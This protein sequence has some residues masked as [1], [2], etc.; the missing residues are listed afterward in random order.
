MKVLITGGLGFVGRNFLKRCLSA[1]DEVTVVD[2]FSE[3]G[4]GLRPETTW[5]QIEKISSHDFE[6][7]EQDCRQFFESNTTKFDMAIHLASIVGGRLTIE[8]DPFEIA[9][10]LEIDLRFFR[11]ALKNPVA[12]VMLFSSS[13]VYPTHLQEFSSKRSLAESDLNPKN[14]SGFP[15]M[16]YG[17]GKLNLEVLT[18][19]FIGRTQTQTRI[20]RPFSGYGV[21]QSLRYPVTNLCRQAHQIKSGEPFLIW[22]TGQQVRDFIHIDDVIEAVYFT[23]EKTSNGEVLNLGMGVPT[24]FI[25]V[26]QIYLKHAKKS[27]EVKAQTQLPSGVQYRCGDPTRLLD[28]GFKFKYDLETGLEQVFRDYPKYSALY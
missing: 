7:V 14:L 13:A 9:Q 11:W 23:K 8:N 21:D 26:A 25:E 16:T 18:H 28:L 2:N 20:F 19:F 12:E 4:G 3:T 5:F 17:W 10:N 27:C 24:S 6:L 22:G 15:D 1:G